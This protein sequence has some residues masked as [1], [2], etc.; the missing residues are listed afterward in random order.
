[1]HYIIAELTPNVESV[2]LSLKIPLLSVAA[3]WYVVHSTVARTLSGCRRQKGSA[4]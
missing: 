4:P 1:M 3:A 2:A